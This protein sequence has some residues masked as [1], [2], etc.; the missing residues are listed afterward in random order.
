MHTEEISPPKSLLLVMV[1][2]SVGQVSICEVQIPAV[3][4][5]RTIMEN[6]DN[7]ADCSSPAVMDSPTAT[8]GQQGESALEVGQQVM[9]DAETGVPRHNKVG[10][11]GKHQPCHHQFNLF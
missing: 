1:L 4:G 10:L 5:G 9:K 3:V 8:Y 6:S 2:T 7:P 11:S